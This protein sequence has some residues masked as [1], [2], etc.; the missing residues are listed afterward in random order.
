MIFSKI[1]LNE[2]REAVKTHMSEHRYRHTLGVEKAAQE[3][4][5]IFCPMA[6]YELRVAA[7]L[8]DI[9]KEMPL[10]L[11]LALLNSHSAALTDEDRAALPALHS[12]SAPIFIKTEFAKY[13][14]EN[15]F[16]ERTQSFLPARKQRLCHH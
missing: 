10:D 16:G 11:Q 2:L 5:A 3:L 4:G 6:V 14:R 13:A 8:H 15:R 7:L 12:F 1:E 9:T